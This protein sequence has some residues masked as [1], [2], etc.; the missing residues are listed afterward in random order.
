MKPPATVD[1]NRAERAALE[2]ADELFF[3]RGVAAVTMAEIR[4]RSGLSLRR[5]YGL[6]PAKTDLVAAWL[7]HRHTVWLAGFER[8]VS[9]ELARGADAVDA[10][11]AALESWMRSTGFRGCGFINTHAETNELTDDHRVIIRRHKR[12]VADYLETLSPLGP[13]LA[14]MVDGAIVQAAIFGDASPIHTTHRAARMLA[15]GN[16]P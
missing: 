10:V 16:R 5:L 13:A 11:F 6:F 15:D 14:V 7:L 1:A 3:N 4:D 8:L 9:D 2:A 12:A